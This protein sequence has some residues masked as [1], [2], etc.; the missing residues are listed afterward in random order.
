MADYQYVTVEQAAN[1]LGVSPRTIR[2]R[3]KNGELKADIVNGRYEVELPDM[4]RQGS[5]AA[6]QKPRQSGQ[7]TRQDP[8]VNALLDRIAS[9]EAELESRRLE[10]QQLH[11]LL[12]RPQLPGPSWWQRLFGRRT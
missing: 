11:S 12:Y 8:Y 5:Q 6:R 2:R 10:V 1:S 3:I 4:A 9:L 7:V